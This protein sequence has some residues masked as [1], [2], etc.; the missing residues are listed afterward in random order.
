MACSAS[1]T[2][3]AVTWA[4]WGK[5]ITVDTGT[6]EPF[7]MSAAAGTS[8]GLTHTDAVPYFAASRQPA[9]TSLGVI[10]GFSSEWSMVL[11]TSVYV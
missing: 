8:H 7:R 9:A 6:P 5:P 10:S 11:A 3:I 2:L 4:P 1:A